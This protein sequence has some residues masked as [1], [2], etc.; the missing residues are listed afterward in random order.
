M[1]SLR[2]I[3]QEAIEA[4]AAVLSAEQLAERTGLTYKQTIDAL[5]ALHN[6]GRI[7]RHGRKFSAR[8]GAVP[9]PPNPNDTPAKHLAD[10]FSTFFITP[11]EPTPMTDASHT[12]TIDPAVAAHPLYSILV[13]AIEQAMYGKGE[14]HGGAVTPFME[15]PW[16]HYA[17][18]HGRGFL[19][20]QA[21][22]KLEEAASLRE[23]KPFVNEML[24]AIVYCGMAVIQEQI[25]CGRMEQTPMTPKEGTRYE[26]QVQD[27]RLLVKGLRG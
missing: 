17:R 9:P 16:A 19:T 5:N 26:D 14:R 15:Q 23:G 10:A 20:G 13:Q 18:L 6:T 8:W 25:N 11:T 27:A 24:G 2:Q 7:V 12:T 4:S 1:K 22:K 21:T 3:V